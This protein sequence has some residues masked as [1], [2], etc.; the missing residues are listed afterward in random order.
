MHK[1][2]Q[3]FLFE[4]TKGASVIGP[5]NSDVGAFVQKLRSAAPK[6]MSTIEI[7]G[8]QKLKSPVAKPQ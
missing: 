3:G 8:T 4:L 2:F 1:F 5:S 6:S 7:K